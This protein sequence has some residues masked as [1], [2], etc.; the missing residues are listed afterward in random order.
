M[1]HTSA[2]GNGGSTTHWARP[3]IKPTSS[4]ILGGI[5]FCCATTGTPGSILWGL[6]VMSGWGGPPIWLVDP[7]MISSPVWTPG[8]C[9]FHMLLSGDSFSKLNSSLMHMCSYILRGPHKGVQS[10]LCTASSLQYS[11]VKFRPLQPP[12]TPSFA[13]SAQGDFPEPFGLP[14][15]VHDL[16]SLSRQWQVGSLVGVTSPHLFPFS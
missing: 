3:G 1:I 13:S 2:H 5:R 10:S 14:R 12:R 6:S 15:S 9:W 16:E 7:W 4:W 11:V 8:V